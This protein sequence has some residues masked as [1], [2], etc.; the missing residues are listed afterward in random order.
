[1]KPS[2][3]SPEQK[4]ALAWS[5]LFATNLPLPLVFGWSAS[6]AH[7]RAGMALAAVVWWALGLWAGRQGPALRRPLLIGAAV[8]AVFQFLVIPHLIAGMIAG[9]VWDVL[10]E[11]LR[12]GRLSTREP[13]LTTVAD[14]LAVTLLTAVELTMVTL[15]IGGICEGLR[16]L[17]TAWRQPTAVAQTPADANR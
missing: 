11:L 15:A 7:A 6:E 9:L 2:M 4:W 17:I 3:P 12:M 8:V 16:T 5:V 14:G 13:Y 10:R 1:M